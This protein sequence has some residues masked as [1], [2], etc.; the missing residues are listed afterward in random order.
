MPSPAI[1]V[2]EYLTIRNL[3]ANPIELKQVERFFPPDVSKSDIWNLAKT[4]TTLMNNVTRSTSTI[5]RIEHDAEAFDRQDVSIL[6]EPFQIVRTEIR[7]FEK[8]DK[9]R[10]R[11][12]FE[13]EGAKHRIQTPVP[14]SESATL[15]H[16]V[17]NR[18]YG[19]TGVFIP[20]ESYLAVYSSASLNAWMR[21]LKDDVLVSALSIP[22]TH[23]SP[24]CH[25]APP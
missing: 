2:S 12:T 8:S 7:A 14:T 5:D 24:T 3:T 22:G 9:E 21:E 20:A 4:F 17:D 10:L 6:V 23:N 1:M 25:M 15:G 19:L 18:R 16:L 13:A 11:L